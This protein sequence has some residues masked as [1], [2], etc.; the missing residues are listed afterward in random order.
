MK[1]QSNKPRKI[2][3]IRNIRITIDYDNTNISLPY[4]DETSKDTL[5]KIVTIN[6]NK[7]ADP[8]QYHAAKG[9]GLIIAEIQHL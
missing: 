7:S 9:A 8:E 2:S 1:S 4:V 3:P 6:T 5:Y